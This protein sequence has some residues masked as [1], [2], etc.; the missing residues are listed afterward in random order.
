MRKPQEG[1][2]KSG[3]VYGGTKNVV[4]SCVAAASTHGDDVTIT[5]S[6][7][8]LII[9]V[10]SLSALTLVGLATYYPVHIY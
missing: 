3:R 5:I 1:G 10:C 2:T 6:S 4:V 8:L 9:A 7:F